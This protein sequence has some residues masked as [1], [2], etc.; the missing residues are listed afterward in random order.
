MPSRRQ[1]WLRYALFASLA[2]PLAAVACLGA[3]SV[4]AWAWIGLAS[5]AA[6]AVLLV[7]ATWDGVRLPWHPILWP[8]A[9][10]GGL[11]LAQYF[12]RWTVYPAATR[13]G[14]LQLAA[15]ACELYL[16]L[17]AMREPANLKRAGTVLWLFSGILGAE[18]LAQ[19]FTAGGYIYW[20][21]D[22]R[23]ATPVGPFIYH[24]H[25]AG[26]MDLLLPVAIAVAMRV[27]RRSRDQPWLARARRGVLP[28]LALA[29]VVVSQSRGGLFALLF[30]SGFAVALFWP[31]LR[32]DPRLRTRALLAAAALVAFTLLAGWQPLIQRLTRLEYHDVSAVYRARVGRTCLAIWQSAPW[33]GTGFGTFPQVYPQYQS[34]DSGQHWEQAHDEYAQMLAET[35]LLGAAAVLAFL[36]LLAVFA[37][38]ARRQLQGTAAAVQIAAL[39]GCAGFLFHSAGDFLFHAPADALLF[40]LLA[41]AVTASA[42]LS[43][44]A[45]KTDA[46]QTGIPASA[47]VRPVMSG[48]IHGP[49]SD[50]APDRA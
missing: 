1:F 8:V 50:G 38:R 9:G 39:I 33:R 19:F 41:G 40:F 11:V 17:F 23:Y 35:G 46:S 2:I 37:W 22:A 31:R 32:R 10:F 5:F 16:A 7:G 25:F 29:A 28:A 49:S 21:R 36:A 14:A 6:L 24:N 18:A 48:Q 15:C 27:R 26:A 42:V 47:P 3:V 4:A 12:F 45:A 43:P 30:E 34:F 44:P 20:Y 13:D